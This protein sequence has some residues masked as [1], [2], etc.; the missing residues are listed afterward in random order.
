MIKYLGDV[1]LE[2]MKNIK[3]VVRKNESLTMLFVAS[4]R[5]LK[6]TL[7]TQT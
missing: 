1:G 2:G 4:V 6:R 5:L 7:H 3:T